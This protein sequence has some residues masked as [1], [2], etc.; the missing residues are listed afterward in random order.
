MLMTGGLQLQIGQPG[1]IS[2]LIP[3]EFGLKKKKKRFRFSPF[4]KSAL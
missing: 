4:L 2:I 1:K 3:S